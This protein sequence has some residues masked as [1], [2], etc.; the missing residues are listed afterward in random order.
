MA[1]S[2]GSPIRPKGMGGADALHDFLREVGDHIGAGHAGCHRI[3]AD[4][5]APQLARQAAGHTVDGKLAGGVA[6]AGRLP[7]QADHRAGV[8]DVAAA[9][10]LHTR[11]S[12]TAAVEH[13]GHVQPHNFFKR[14]G[15]VV[16]Q[17]LTRRNAR[18]VDKDVDPAKGFFDLGKGGIDGGVVR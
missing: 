8:D 6:H 5:I 16:V 2:S 18:V 13:G 10:R 9:L 4:V 7:V 15:G 3:D 14:F 11:G 1:T 17:R 12:R